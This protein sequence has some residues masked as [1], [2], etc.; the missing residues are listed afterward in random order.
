MGYELRWRGKI[1]AIDMSV[2]NWRRGRRKDNHLST[3]FS[4]HADNLSARG[5]TDYT[6]INKEDGPTCKFRR[7]SAK[8]PVYRFLTVTL[9]GNN[10]GSEDV[11]VLHETLAV[12]NFQTGE[13][14]SCCVRHIRNGDDDI[15]IYNNILA[16]G[17]DNSIGQ[18]LAHILSTL[19]N[20]NAINSR[21]WT[22]EIHVF[23]AIRGIWE[24][25]NN[26]T[27][28]WL[29]CFAKHGLSRKDINN[30]TESKLRRATNSE[31]TM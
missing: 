19:V 8:L 28:S 10:E 30:V 7:Y 21:I 18:L 2:S 24:L 12:W 31:A 23:E 9:P 1:N 11:T 27:E 14:G 4:G 15:Y 29:A 16:K 25:W 5:A 26:L 22:S 20:A 17:F 13:T 3:C 6:I